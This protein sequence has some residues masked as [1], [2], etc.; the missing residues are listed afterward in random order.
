MK[1]RT[2]LTSLGIVILVIIAVAGFFIYPQYKSFMTVETVLYDKDLTF[3]LS[4]GG[5]SGV[6]VTDSALVVIDSKMSKPAKTLY[7]IVK[8]KAGS[9][10]IIVI[11]THYHG[12]HVNG[13]HYYKGDKIYIGSYSK[14]FIAKNIEPENQ[15]NIFIKD[16]LLLNLGNESILMVNLGQGHTYDDMVV[17]LVK[18]RI[19]FTGDLVTNKMNPFLKKE[20]GANVDKWIS[21]LERIIKGFDMVTVV[22]GHGKIGGKELPVSMYD[23]FN[24]MKIAASDSQREKEL[25]AKYASWTNIPGMSSP[26]ATIKY[27]KGK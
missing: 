7:D 18:H 6:L 19:L 20:S 1:R 3:Y 15:P 24:D 16:S 26:A 13:N 11:N 17:Y 8:E 9:K 23:Y 5:N 10:H 14:E 25:T 21:V 2:I 22:P 12:D 4:G 27:I